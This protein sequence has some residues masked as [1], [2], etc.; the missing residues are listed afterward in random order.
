[1]TKLSEHFDSSE[2][3][4]HCGCGNDNVHSALIHALEILRAMVK[5]P[6]IITS[7]R[8][9]SKHN[10]A[11]G[12]AKNSWHLSGCAVDIATPKHLT[13]EQFFKVA[14]S[15]KDFGGVGLYEGRIHVDIRPRKAVTWRNK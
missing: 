13:D 12:G 5:S 6:L 3:A 9:C 14:L 8:R 2:F 1:M 7:G 4:C 11:V 15:I 10:K